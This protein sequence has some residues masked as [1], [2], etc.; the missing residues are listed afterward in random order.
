MASK[1]GR[2]SHGA[3]RIVD[4]F[5]HWRQPPGYAF[6]DF[7]ENAHRAEQDTSLLDGGKPGVVNFAVELDWSDKLAMRSLCTACLH[8]PLQRV[9]EV[10]PIKSVSIHHGQKHG[11]P[12]AKYAAQLA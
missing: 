12:R 5:Q 2:P 9:V 4:G 7:V 10:E 6:A 3:D 8:H 11:A 1:W